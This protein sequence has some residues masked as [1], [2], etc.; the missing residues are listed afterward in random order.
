MFKAVEKALSEQ[1]WKTAIED[2]LPDLKQ[3]A[4]HREDSILHAITRLDVLLMIPGNNPTTAPG[5][6]LFFIFLADPEKVEDMRTI[7]KLLRNDNF[8]ALR[9]KCDAVLQRIGITVQE[10]YVSI[11]TRPRS[12]RTRFTKERI[13]VPA[14][15]VEISYWIPT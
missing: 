15:L 5:I 12:I 3:L 6:S 11:A 13:S 9:Q 4:C 8:L 10:P 7:G 1:G 14:F 2:D